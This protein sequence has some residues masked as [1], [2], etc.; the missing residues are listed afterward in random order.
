[1]KESEDIIDDDVD[2]DN[3]LDANLGDVSFTY[4]LSL[5]DSSFSADLIDLNLT[6][7]DFMDMDSDQVKLPSSMAM[8]INTVFNAEEALLPNREAIYQINHDVKKKD[9]ERIGGQRTCPRSS[10]SVA[11]QGHAIKPQNYKSLKAVPPIKIT[12]EYNKYKISKRRNLLVNSQSCPVGSSPSKQMKTSKMSR[13]ISPAP[14]FISCPLC[15]KKF[16]RGSQCK[17]TKHLSSSHNSDM[18]YS[19][20]YC[21]KQFTCQSIL[22]AHTV[23]HQLTN[24]WQCDECGGRF[25]NIK[26][27]IEHVKRNHQ[28]V[29]LATVRRLLVSA[30][31]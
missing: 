26:Q 4:L 1:M 21:D 27:F 20:K 5:I 14:Q 15:S 17:L 28:A 30:T 24:P 16:L 2:I 13:D 31:D 8:D 22:T 9:L 11:G 29:S 10:E 6:N 23:W 25:E 18:A 12:K 19:C 7:L 3:L